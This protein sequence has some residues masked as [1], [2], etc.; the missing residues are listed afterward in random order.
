MDGHC[1]EDESDDMAEPEVVKRDDPKQVGEEVEQ[2]VMEHEAEWG[3]VWSKN[4]ESS[5]APSNCP[6][7]PIQTKV[8]VFLNEVAEDDEVDYTVRNGPFE[9]ELHIIEKHGL[10]EVTL[11]QVLFRDGQENPL[12][13]WQVCL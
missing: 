2:K 3:Q 13:L 8:S 10:P 1:D 6:K 12:F 11:K 9:I 4:D 7:I 5:S